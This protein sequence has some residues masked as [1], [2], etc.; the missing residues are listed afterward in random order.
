VSTTD[1]QNGHD[2]HVLDKPV[3]SVVFVRW[4]RLIIH[5]RLILGLYGMILSSI[6]AVANALWQFVKLGQHRSYRCH[7]YADDTQL[8]LA[9]RVDNTAAGLSILAACATDVKLW[10]IQ[11][12]LQLNPDKSEELFMR[13]ATHL[14][15][16]SSLTSV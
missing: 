4:S 9:M 14:Q 10:Y 16:V 6:V 13:T 3:M 7:Q 1:G 12:G 8:H 11:N 15:A 2:K 5:V